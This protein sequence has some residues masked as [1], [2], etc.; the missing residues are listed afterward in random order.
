MGKTKVL[1]A[2]GGTGGHVYPAIAIAD[3]L[4]ESSADTEILFTGTKNHMEWD[5]VSKAG[6]NITSIWISGFHRRF[7]LK[8]LLFPVKLATSIVQSFVIIKKYNPDVV[9]SCGGYVAGPVGWVATKMGIPL[10]I[11]EQN[12]FPGVTNRILGKSAALI[13]TAFDDAE[14]HFPE[15]KTQLTGNPTRKSLSQANRKEAVQA[16]D[17]SSDKKTLL[18]LGGSGGAKKINK[19]MQKHIE[20]LH[21]DSGLQI[22][23]QCGKRYY[24]K[25]R[26]DVKPQNFENLRLKDFIHDMPAAYA[27][28]DLVISRAGAL[29]C[30][31]LAL[32]SK[33]SILVPSPNVAGDH[34]TKNA[35]SMVD[36]G[37][38]KLV[39]DDDLESSLANVVKE[40][41]DDEQRLKE[42]SK[43]AK[44][45]ARPNAAEEIAT[46]ILKLVKNKI[47]A[48][49]C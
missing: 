24:D 20:T 4:R 32:T 39:A 14:K 35:R 28:S 25:L 27:A 3:A 49:S 5:T 43:A 30:S 1:I 48:V 38:A 44:N 2:A 46:E 22:I 47:T 41:I 19:A 16:F 15:E 21:N 37:A 45:L 40:I 10:V 17:F 18:I 29:S 7:T 36:E 11:Q 6:Y 42:M 8:N 13:F 9:I 12:S 34:Q 26:K 23:W 31:E 33:P